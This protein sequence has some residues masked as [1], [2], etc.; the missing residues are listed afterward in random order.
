MG[1]RWKRAKKV[2]RRLH[3][4]GSFLKRKSLKL[5]AISLSDS[6]LDKF[7]T[8]TYHTQAFGRGLTSNA[9]EMSRGNSK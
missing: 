2:S 8:F 1:Q 3:D 6:V 7:L 9:V 5:L 4:N